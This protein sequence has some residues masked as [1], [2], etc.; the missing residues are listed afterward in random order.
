MQASLGPASFRAGSWFW[1]VH[2][3]ALWPGLTL[4]LPAGSQQDLC[5]Y[6]FIHGEPSLRNSLSSSE[7]LGKTQQDDFVLKKNLNHPSCHFLEFSCDDF[8]DFSLKFTV[9]IF[10]LRILEKGSLVQCDTE[11][12]GVVF[13][14]LQTS[15]FH[16]LGASLSTDHGNFSWTPCSNSSS[17][18]AAAIFHVSCVFRVKLWGKKFRYS[19][20]QIFKY[21]DIQ[22]FG[23]LYIQIFRYCCWTKPRGALCLWPCSPAASHASTPNAPWFLGML[24][25]SGFWECSYSLGF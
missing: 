5:F 7:V 24:L 16:T 8:E 18:P 2:K 4:P 15:R 23:Y 17:S 3:A 10:P 21:T 13:Y 19:D 1:A 20:I 9:K 11:S 14:W 25:F 6:C 22:I 12:L